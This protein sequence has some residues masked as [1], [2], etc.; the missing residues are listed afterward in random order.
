ML[1]ESRLV[2]ELV[3]HLGCRVVHCPLLSPFEPQTATLH[4]T[5]P[6]PL[7]VLLTSLEV[8]PPHREV[9]RLLLAKVAERNLA[10]YELNGWADLPARPRRSRR[11][12]LPP[13]VP[14]SAGGPV[15]VCLDTSWSMEGPRETL[16]K[17]LVVEA[18]RSPTLCRV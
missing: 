9:R 14:T 3:V 16:A 7:S 1:M 12:T 2:G 17:A 10:T 8:D 18:V 6:P 5:S 11:R 4:L 13:R 15:I